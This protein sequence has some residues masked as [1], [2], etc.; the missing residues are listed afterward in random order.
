[1]WGL[2]VQWQTWRRTF[3][4]NEPAVD[5]LRKLA[6]NG[7]GFRLEQVDYLPPGAAA[8]AEVRG[9]VLA[10]GADGQV[11]IAPVIS[12]AW[13]PGAPAAAQNELTLQLAGN[14]AAALAKLIKRHRC[15]G[16]TVAWKATAALPGPL[17]VAGTSLTPVP[18][19]P[20][21]LVEP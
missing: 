13:A 7:K 19:P 6:R 9:L 11:W 8:G 1:L 20:R 4:T 15:A 14:D 3:I 5:V 10:R 18:P 12:Y 16:L 2:Y 21:V 17:Q